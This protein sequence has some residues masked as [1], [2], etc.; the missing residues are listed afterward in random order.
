MGTELSQ[1]EISDLLSEPRV[2]HLATVRPDGRPQVAPAVGYFEEIG[3]VYSF[4]TG[5]RV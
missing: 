3:K 4:T 2:A 5:D 1:Q